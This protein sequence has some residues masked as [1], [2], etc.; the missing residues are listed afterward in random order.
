MFTVFVPQWGHL[1]FD[2]V[3]ISFQ[4]KMSSA[5]H[6][7]SYLD[8][9]LS[10]VSAGPVVELHHHQ[11]VAQRLDGPVHAHN[12]P[13]AL[14]GHIQVV[15][16][17]SS[18]DLQHVIRSA[19]I[20]KNLTERWEERPRRTPAGGGGQR[21]SGSSPPDPTPPKTED[22]RLKAAIHVVRHEQQ[23]AELLQSDELHVPLI[24]LTHLQ[25]LQQGVWVH[26]RHDG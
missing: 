15:G 1:K 23:H 18:C 2:H 16:D 11:P 12:P 13:G 21:Q 14:G 25:P 7:S 24:A 17:G 26:I 8:T 4:R 3:Y 10:Q 6:P 22:S 9:L 5:R 19:L 20:Q